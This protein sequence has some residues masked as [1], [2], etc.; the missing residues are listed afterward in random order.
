MLGQLSQAVVTGQCFQQKVPDSL[1]QKQI[2]LTAIVLRTA[3]F[4]AFGSGTDIR[5]D[6]DR[7]SVV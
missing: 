6:I 4:P 5:K 3:Q 7:K 2:R 1:F